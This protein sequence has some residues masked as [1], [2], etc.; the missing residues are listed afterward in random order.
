MGRM[1]KLSVA[2]RQQARVALYEDLDAGRLTSLADTVRRMRQVTGMTQAD[3][4][5]KVA[6]VSKLTI[7]QI[8]RGEG[9]PTVDTLERVGRAFGLRLGFVRV[10]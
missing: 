1:K 10:P 3:F 2:E 7:A 4:A 8:E 6:G 5:E 9:N